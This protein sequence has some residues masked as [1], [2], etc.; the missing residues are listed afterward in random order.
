MCYSCFCFVHSAKETLEPP[1]EPSTRGHPAELPRSSQSEKPEKQEN[2][3]DAKETLQGSCLRFVVAQPSTLW[4][5]V[6]LCSTHTGTSY[7]CSGWSFTV[8]VTTLSQATSHL[9]ARQVASCNVLFLFLFCPPISKGDLGTANGAFN[10]RAPWTAAFFTCEAR[11]WGRQGQ[12]GNGSGQKPI[13]GDDSPMVF[14]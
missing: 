11:N 13:D 5:V 10:K 1:T 14:P 9:I 3:E 12:V 7:P 8:L 2:A 4:L 6:R